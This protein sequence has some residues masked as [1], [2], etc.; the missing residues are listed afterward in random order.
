MIK[1]ILCLN[2]I[3]E[4]GKSLTCLSE[5]IRIFSPKGKL[6]VADFN[7]LGFDV[8]DGLHIVRFGHLNKGEKF[9]HIK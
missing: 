8:M 6:L 7:S 1:N 5:I 3:H 4:L 9:H 2:T